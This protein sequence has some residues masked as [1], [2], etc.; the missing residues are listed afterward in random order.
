MGYTEYPKDELLDKE[1]DEWVAEAASSIFWAFVIGVLYFVS[2]VGG[3]EGWYVVLGILWIESIV[4]R[5]LY[6][7]YARYREKAWMGRWMEW[8]TLLPFVVFP[9][10]LVFLLLDIRVLILG[11]MIAL[12]AWLAIWRIYLEK[13]IHDF[14]W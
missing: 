7:R 8:L 2:G 14:W 6:Y 1:E 5:L 12:L 4:Y 11:E 3:G 13:R 9:F 10:V